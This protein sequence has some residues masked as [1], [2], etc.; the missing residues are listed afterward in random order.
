[1]KKVLFFAIITA[2]GCRHHSPHLSL[3]QKFQS[4]AEVVREDFITRMPDVKNVDTLY[5]VVKGITAQDKGVMQYA[6]Y[7]RAAREAH[8]T[9]NADSTLLKEM[10]NRVFDEAMSQ[11]STRVQYF[12]AANI[13]IYTNKKSQ[14]CM[15]EDWLFFDKELNRV[16][17]SAFIEKVS[18]NDDEAIRPEQYEPIN[19]KDQENLNNN[20]FLE[21]SWK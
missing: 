6:A 10:G 8:D 2:I 11:D 12:R 7:C 5:L 13:I 4:I 3:H 20:G 16:P 9:G 21:Y 18:K 19:K 1:M 14:K 17:E 15:A